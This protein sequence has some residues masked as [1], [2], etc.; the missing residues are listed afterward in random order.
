MRHVCTHCYMIQK[1]K[2]Q[3]LPHLRQREI[4]GKRIITKYDEIKP[5]TEN[6]IYDWFEG[7]NNFQTRKDVDE[8]LVDDNRLEGV[9]GITLLKSFGSF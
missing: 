8:Y 3:W 7:F 5:M 9:P 4:S 2:L 6:E 1:T